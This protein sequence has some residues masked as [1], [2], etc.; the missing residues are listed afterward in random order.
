MS[1]SITGLVITDRIIEIECCIDEWTTGTRMDVPFT[2]HDYCVGYESHLKC[3]QDFDEATKEFGVLK[4]ICA[5]I[6]EDGR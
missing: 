3:L 2:V 6:Y 4:G 5:W 1:C